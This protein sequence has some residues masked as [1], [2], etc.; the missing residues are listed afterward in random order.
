ML[1]AQLRI[2]GW[3]ERVRQQEFN[4]IVAVSHADMIK[5]ALAYTLGLPLQNLDRFDID[6]GSISRLTI[7]GWGSKVLSIN[8]RP[9]CPS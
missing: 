2:V 4:A 9:S 3:L 5:A 6:P 8:E 1:E 7:G